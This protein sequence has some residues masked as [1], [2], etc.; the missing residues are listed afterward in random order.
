MK[1]LK[2]ILPL[3]M[4]LAVSFSAHASEPCLAGAATEFGVPP[5]VLDAIRR[6][7]RAPLNPSMASR[8]FGLMGL[9]EP[10]LQAAKTGAGID[11]ER[12]KRESC[13]NYRAA[14]W[15]LA[16]ARKRS[17]GNLWAAVKL[18]RGGRSA[19][20]DSYVKRIQIASCWKVCP[21]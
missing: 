3:A 6:E 4:L 2:V 14:A 1:N 11:R 18:Y 12:A 7:E 8:E 17:G 15:F 9:S 5:A 16:D 21:R 13:E 20:A 19:E 10:A